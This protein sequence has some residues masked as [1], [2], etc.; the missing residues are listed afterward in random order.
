MAVKTIFDN[1]QS[2]F[3]N[4][5]LQST[6]M[7]K[8]AEANT[9][10][11]AAKAT[12]QFKELGRPTYSWVNDPR[13]LQIAPNTYDYKTMPY[14]GTYGLGLANAGINEDNIGYYLNLMRNKD[15]T[16]DKSGG[17]K[18]IYGHMEKWSD[19]YNPQLKQYL[20]TG[21]PTKGVSADTILQATDYGIRAAAQKQQNKVRGFLGPMLEGNIGAIAGTAFGLTPWGMASGGPAVWGTIGG[22]THG[23]VKAGGNPFSKQAIG[24]A[25]T[26]YSLGSSAGWAG[27]KVAPK[28]MAAHSPK[29]TAISATGQPTFQP[30]TNPIAQA[31]TATKAAIAGTTIPLTGGKT[32]GQVGSA[33]SGATVPLTAGKT[34]GQ[35][36]S[37]AG[38]TAL[39]AAQLAALGETARDIEL[40]TTPQSILEAGQITPQFTQASPIANPIDIGNIF[41]SQPTV[42]SGNLGLPANPLSGKGYY[43]QLAS[44]LALNTS[45]PSLNVS[46][47]ALSR[48]NQRFSPFRT[49]VTLQNSYRRL[50][51]LAIV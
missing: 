46:P 23:T 8:Q 44:A 22:G 15:A 32:V 13:L 48:A 5:F 20:K 47:E 12:Q 18:E 1:A 31:G 9:Q 27:G 37:T 42:A 4:P 26:G 16:G 51:P 49:P 34:V 30:S 25:L 7:S 36:A 19:Q 21:K 45:L 14:Q 10:K 50:N 33:I 38:K 11:K 28:Y 24:D 29:V 35:L 2:G 41:A 40:A 3:V 17:W 6:A 43:N 39:T